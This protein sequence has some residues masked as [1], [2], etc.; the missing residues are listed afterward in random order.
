MSVLFNN[1]NSKNLH[2]KPAI[3]PVVYLIH[4]GCQL[5]AIWTALPLSLIWWTVR[6]MMIPWLLQM[7]IQNCLTNVIDSTFMKWKENLWYLIHSEFSFIFKIQVHKNGMA[8]TCSFMTCV[9]VG[10]LFL[11]NNK[12][13]QYLALF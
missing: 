11:Y 2:E 13:S 8:F 9:L 5:R 4:L 7:P 1:I 3:L 12:F 10:F 6:L